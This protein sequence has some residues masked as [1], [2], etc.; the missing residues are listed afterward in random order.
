[1]RYLR[2][3]WYVAFRDDKVKPRVS[4]SLRPLGE[5]VVVFQDTGGTSQA[6][7]DRCPHRFAPLSEE[8]FAATRFSVS[9][10]VWNL[11]DRMRKSLKS[12]NELS[13]E[14][15]L[16]FAKKRNEASDI[17]SFELMEPDGRFRVDYLFNLGVADSLG[18]C[19]HGLRLGFN[20][21][22]CIK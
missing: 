5:Q 9:T 6:F 20:K 17:C 2:K 18:N 7:F 21:V 19:P 3:F 1:M 4:P 13:A 16:L 14:M 10:M 8:R 11:T 12:A 22:V 15:K